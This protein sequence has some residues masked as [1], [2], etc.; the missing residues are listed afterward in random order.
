MVLK[1]DFLPQL[2]KPTVGVDDHRRAEDAGKLFTIPLLFT[3]ESHL[4]DDGA[5]HIGE[6]GKV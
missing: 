3:P 5:I 1:L 6:E 2:L 4:V